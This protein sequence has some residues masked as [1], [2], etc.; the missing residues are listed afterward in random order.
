MQEKPRKIN[1]INDFSLG[2]FEFK[3]LRAFTHI[4]EVLDSIPSSLDIA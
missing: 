2:G 1:K 4:P 3:L